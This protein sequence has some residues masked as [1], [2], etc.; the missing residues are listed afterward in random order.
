MIPALQRTFRKVSKVSLNLSLGHLS[1]R[2]DQVTNLKKI[3]RLNCPK[4]TVMQLSLNYKVSTYST[5]LKTYT[6]DYIWLANIA[7]DI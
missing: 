5:S 1:K 6:I 2:G 4:Y 7:T 3:L